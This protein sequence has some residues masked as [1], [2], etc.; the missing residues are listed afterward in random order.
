MTRIINF[1]ESVAGKE[2]KTV[3]KICSINGQ[4]SDI[5]LFFPATDQVG[6]GVGFESKR[7]CPET[8]FIFLNNKSPSFSVN[9]EIKRNQRLWVE[10]QNQSDATFVISAIITI[11]SKEVIN[12]RN[13]DR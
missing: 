4:I 3:S 2:Q 13:M 8:G 6:L 10:I 12:E 1:H 9:E 5:K 11:I 7:V